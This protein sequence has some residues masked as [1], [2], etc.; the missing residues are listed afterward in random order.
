MSKLFIENSTLTAIGDA[1]REKTGKTALIAPGAMP[2]EIK[3]I[4]SGGGGGEGDCNGLHIPED[5]LVL[6]GDCQY[7]FTKGW[8]WFLRDFG[9]RITTEKIWQP[10][11]MFHLVKI[12]NIPFAINLGNPAVRDYQIMDH[13][14]NNCEYLTACPPINNARPSRVDNLFYGCYAL[15][16]IPDNLTKTWDW[17]MIEGAASSYEAQMNAMFQYC[18]KLRKIP[19]DLISHTNPSINYNYAIYKNG[20][21]DCYSL[22]AIEDLAVPYSATWTSNAFGYAFSNCYRLKK[23]TFK[24]QADG[25]PYT[26]NW[27]SQ[28]IDLSLYVGYCQSGYNSLDKFGFTNATKITNQSQRTDYKNASLS[29]STPGT[30]EY[31]GWT[32][33]YAWSTFGATAAK[34]MFETL[35]DTSAYL[36]SAGGTNTIKLNSKAAMLDPYDKMSLLTEEDIA[37]AAAKGWTVSL[38]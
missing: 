13:M 32:D 8:E 35:P 36:A 38:V 6:T 27:K 19:K 28:V 7:K 30:F 23:L 2:A 18:K 20:F 22:V 16:T 29:E 3:S 33:D 15:E 25:T 1:I 21:Q 24:K 9:D 5:A 17:S 31:D 37:V 26:A 34:E 12:T 14:F 4:V 11:Y 10:Q